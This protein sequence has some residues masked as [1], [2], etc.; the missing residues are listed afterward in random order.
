LHRCFNLVQI[1]H[2]KMSKAIPTDLRNA[3][4]VQQKILLLE[5]DADTAQVVETILKKAGYKCLVKPETIDIIALVN[6]YQPNL[7]ILDYVL[8]EINGGEICSTIKNDSNCSHLPVIIY[9]SYP[10]SFLS[11][12]QYQCDAFI[13]KPF[14]TDKL[15]AKIKELFQPIADN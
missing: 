12:R 3:S 11:L 4:P 6:E 9:S 10:K 7:V 2:P 8:P 13:P 5:N 1:N 14:D 15:M